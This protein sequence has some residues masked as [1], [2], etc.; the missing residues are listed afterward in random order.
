MTPVQRRV[1][2]R[3]GCV[4]PCGG[5]PPAL[6]QQWISRSSNLQRRMQYDTHLDRDVR[7]R[8]V[9]D[10]LALVLVHNLHL[11]QRKDLRIASDCASDT[12]DTARARDSLP[13]CLHEA[14]HCQMTGVGSHQG[15]LKRLCLT[16][17]KARWPTAMACGGSRS[18]GAWRQTTRECMASGAAC[19]TQV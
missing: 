16:R 18:L 17:C 9:A 2:V 3:G 4:P 14:S 6:L 19:G 15:R 11:L 8:L 7:V 13:Y 5:S 12:H 1:A 10:E